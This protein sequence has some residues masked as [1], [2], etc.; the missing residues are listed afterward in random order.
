MLKKFLNLPFG[1]FIR[2]YKN[3]QNYHDNRAQ[4]LQEC[5]YTVNKPK[6]TGNC[7]ISRRR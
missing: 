7:K 3:H 6:N 1:N 5:E 2:Q 4:E